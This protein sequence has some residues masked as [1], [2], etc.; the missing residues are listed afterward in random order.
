MNLSRLAVNQLSEAATAFY[1]DYLSAIDAKDIVRYAQ[2][3]SDDVW[4][5]FNN[6]P[7]VKG[8]EAV[9]AMLGQYWQSYDTITHQPLVITGNDRHF[10]ME[11]LNHYRRHDGGEVTVR[12]VA[13]TSVNDDGQVKAIRVYADVGPVF[14]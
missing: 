13:F 10:A 7:E 5:S 3:L 14:A 9:V 8:K 1:M 2:F 4:I 11:A 6:E 12:A